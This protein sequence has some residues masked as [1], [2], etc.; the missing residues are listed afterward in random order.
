[1][2]TLLSLEQLE[3]MLKTLQLWQQLW[4]RLMDKGEVERYQKLL[5]QEDAA[6]GSTPA[7]GSR[8]RE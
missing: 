8:G 3:M 6:A 7:A 5:R 1:M 2:K 4:H